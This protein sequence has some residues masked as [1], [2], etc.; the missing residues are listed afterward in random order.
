MFNKSFSIIIPFFLIYQAFHH[1][2]VAVHPTDV[3]GV[4]EI[5]FCDQSASVVTKKRLLGW[6]PDHACRVTNPT[7]NF[8]FPCNSIK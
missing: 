5:I 2:P 4:Y 7:Y 8:C 1:D 3:D 6:H